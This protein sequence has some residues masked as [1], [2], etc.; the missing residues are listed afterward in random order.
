[1]PRFL[2]IA[3]DERTVHAVTLVRRATAAEVSAHVV[4]I[5]PEGP[6]RARLT[7]ALRKV[8]E[9][10]G[11]VDD[12]AVVLSGALLSSRRLTMPFA[13]REKIANTVKF[14]LEHLLPRPPEAVVADSLVINTS[15]AGAAVLA[16]AAEKVRIADVLHACEAAGLDPVAVDSGLLALWKLFSERGL[17]DGDTVVVDADEYRLEALICVEG[18]PRAMRTIPFASEPDASVDENGALIAVTDLVRSVSAVG[19]QPGKLVLLGPAAASGVIRNTLETVLGLECDQLGGEP[20]GFDAPPDYAVC[21]QGALAAARIAAGLQE[22]VIDLRREEFFYKRS[23]EALAKPLAVLLLALAV[24]FGALAYGRHRQ[25]GR[26]RAE[27]AK[28]E[29]EAE[30]AWGEV[31]PGKD[32][33]GVAISDLIRSERNQLE[34]GMSS[35]PKHLL[36]SFSALDALQDVMKRVPENVKFIPTRIEVSAPGD[37]RGATIRIAVET[38]SAESA[39]DIKEAIETGA[40]HLNVKSPDIETPR[41]GLTTFSLDIEVTGDAEGG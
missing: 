36:R 37:D 34:A 18:A 24:A 35:R 10:C 41:A 4:E 22:P 23:F 39:E 40:P 3:I 28:L 13:D 16:V 12:C 30:K 17:L 5:K 38:D 21:F 33:P 25:A 20:K 1:M 27:L 32:S 9:L 15:V 19:A 31:F 29:K 14:E 8:R 26:L 6:R 11:P 2:G 7:E